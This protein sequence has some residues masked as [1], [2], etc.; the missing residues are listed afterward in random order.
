MRCAWSTLQGTRITKTAL[1][2][3]YIPNA[4]DKDKYKSMLLCYTNIN[5]VKRHQFVFSDVLR[6]SSERNSS[7]KD[8]VHLLDIRELKLCS[9]A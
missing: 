2:H 9:R 7:M 4:E 1:R 8:D 5:F 3:R 6:T